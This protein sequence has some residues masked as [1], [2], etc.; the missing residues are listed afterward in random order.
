MGNV[1]TSKNDYE[2]WFNK[3][4]SYKVLAASGQVKATDGILNGI[5]VS[6]GTPTVLV[7]DTT[8]TTGT[9]LIASVVTAVAGNYQFPG[10]VKFDNGCYV[11][12]TNA[13]TVT[14]LYK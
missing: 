13:G 11:S 7:Y 14:V 3:P 9:I 1:G 5:F 10:G 2:Y 4:A 8:G 6:S 12:L